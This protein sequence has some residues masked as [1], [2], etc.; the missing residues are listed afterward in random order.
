MS[1]TGKILFDDVDIYT[2]YGVFAIRGSFN[3][4]VRLPDMKEP[5]KYSWDTEHGDDVY[6]DDRKIQ[7]RDVSITFLLSGATKEE[8]WDNR[9]TFFEALSADGWHTLD[10]NTLG[11]RFTVYYV[12]CEGAKFINAGK[13]RIELKIKF[14]IDVSTQESEEI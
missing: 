7:A 11:R 8:M 13:K 1:Q 2:T 5:S 12:G 10:I 14:R 6:L 3:D 9:Q 4:L